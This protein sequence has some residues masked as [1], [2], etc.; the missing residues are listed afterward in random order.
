MGASAC[1]DACPDTS[2]QRH[3]HRLSGRWDVDDEASAVERGVERGDGGRFVERWVRGTRIPGDSAA[4]ETSTQSWTGRPSTST[5]WAGRRRIT[6]RGSACGRT[7]ALGRTA[8]IGSAFRPGAR[9]SSMATPAFRPRARRHRS[10]AETRTDGRRAFEM[11]QTL[12]AV[13]RRIEPEQ[14]GILCIRVVAHAE[15]QRRV[16][17]R[18]QQA[19]QMPVGIVALQRRGWRAEATRATS[20]G[21]RTPKPNSV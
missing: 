21:V 7:T 17:E 12:P 5:R 14:G 10:R 19:G 6:Y 3:R 13:V 1:G 20:S 2:C 8:G 16:A 18:L 11:V 15:R 4:G 9:S